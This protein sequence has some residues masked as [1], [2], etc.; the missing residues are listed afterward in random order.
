MVLG[1]R[2]LSVLLLGVAAM[3]FYLTLLSMTS[4]GAQTRAGAQNGNAVAS[5]GDAQCVDSNGASTGDQQTSQNGNEITGDQQTQ[6][7]QS[8][9]SSNSNGVVQRFQQTQNTGHMYQQTLQNGNKVTSDQQTQQITSDQRTSQNGNEITGDQQTLQNEGGG[10][11]SPDAGQNGTGECVIADTVPNESLPPTGALAGKFRAD[12]TA[13]EKEKNSDRGEK[14]ESPSTVQKKSNSRETQR[15]AN[16]NGAQKKANSNKVQ[17]KSN[18]SQTQKK[19]NQ[20]LSRTVTLQYP[21]AKVQIEDRSGT[22][23]RQEKLKTGSKSAAA[24]DLAPVLAANWAPPS[25]EEVAS[26]DKPRHFAPNPGAEM[27][28]SARTL[29]IYDVPVA[30]SG[31]PEDLDNGLIRVPETSLP[32]DGGTQRN[33]YI[34]GHY[35]GYAGTPSRLAFYNLHKLENGDEL[36]LKD[37]LGQMYKYQVSEKF[38]VGPEDSWAMGQVRNRDMVTLQTC[39]PP[40]FGKRLVVRANRVK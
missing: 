25:T 29:G 32:W 12:E 11:T 10:T 1:R 18:S 14:P 39:I 6:Q 5:A 21:G 2:R 15:K 35:L 8:Q 30:S 19:S 31:R 27:T 28:L 38:A 20:K 4:S 26:T 37:G 23:P 3:F 40:D 9:N 36:V 13:A 17:K 24:S 22:G 16:S 34:A 33:V 7:V